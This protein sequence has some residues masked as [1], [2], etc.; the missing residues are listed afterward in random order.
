MKVLTHE[1]F[2]VSAQE[3]AKYNLPAAAKYGITIT[4][5]CTREELWELVEAL[6]VLEKP[7]TPVGTAIRGEIFVTNGVD[8]REGY[9][10]GDRVMAMR[11]ERGEQDAVIIGIVMEE[12]DGCPFK[13]K[14]ADG[15]MRWF[16]SIQLKRIG[17]DGLL[18][19]KYNN[20]DRVYVRSRGNGVIRG[21]SVVNPRGEF[22]Y[23]VEMSDGNF[24]LSVPEEEILDAFETPA[25]RVNRKRRSTK[26]RA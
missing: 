4:V 26:R 1:G 13:V 6:R 12:D 10:V 24:D 21:C 14:F 17:A 3:T 20:G 2:D 23:R 7:P 15:L 18:M 25:T 9:R 16:A 8:S 19:P 22:Y 11:G 5:A